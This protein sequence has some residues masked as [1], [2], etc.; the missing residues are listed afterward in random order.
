[1]S[2]EKHSPAP[3]YNV[4]IGSKRYTIS[5]DEYPVSRVIMDNKYNEANAKIIAAAPELLKACQEMHSLFL[6]RYP[7][8]Y[9]V[10]EDVF[11]N[12]CKAIKKATE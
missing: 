12:A 9:G 5:K 6:D 8:S 1:M 10:T 4:L 11:E 7:Y 2:I 3:W